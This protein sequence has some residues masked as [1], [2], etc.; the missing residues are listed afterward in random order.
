VASRAGTDPVAVAAAWLHDVIE[1]TGLAAQELLEAGMPPEVVEVVTLLT[2]PESQEYDSYLAAIAA[3]P[4][5][6]R[7]KIADML[8]NLSDQPT[9]K[10]IV[11][12]AKG[13]LKL[14]SPPEVAE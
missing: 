11:K 3:H 7:V 13:L 14:V 2:H 5:A 1:D 4:I 6:K 8:T 12:Y 9:D 10:Q